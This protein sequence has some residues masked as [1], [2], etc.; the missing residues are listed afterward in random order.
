MRNHFPEAKRKSDRSVVVMQGRRWWIA[1]VLNKR[2]WQFMFTGYWLISPHYYDDEQMYWW[3]AVPRHMTQGSCTPLSGLVLYPSCV[4]FYW[5]NFTNLWCLSFST[6]N[7][8]YPYFLTPIISLLILL[9]FLS[10]SVTLPPPSLPAPTPYKSF[11]SSSFFAPCSHL[12]PSTSLQLFPPPPPSLPALIY[13]LSTFSTSST[14]SPSCPHFLHLHHSPFLLSSSA[15]SCQVPHSV[16]AIHYF[17]L[18]KR[19]CVDATC[20]RIRNEIEAVWGKVKVSI[21]RTTCIINSDNVKLH[22]ISVRCYRI[23]VV[24]TYARYLRSPYLWLDPPES[25]RT[26]INLSVDIPVVN[27]DLRHISITS[28][29]I[30]HNLGHQK[31]RQQSSDIR[32]FH[33]VGWHHPQWKR[34]SDLDLRSARID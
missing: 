2:S 33:L 12:T 16:A 19:S 24:A 22:I 4:H 26:Y 34:W 20:V 21:W 11:V 8:S 6:S 17:R 31:W 14:S 18:S 32:R 10:L 15:A 23:L 7:S 30:T 5:L 29:M 13:S 3:D 28:W 9:P 1:I 25:V 27:H